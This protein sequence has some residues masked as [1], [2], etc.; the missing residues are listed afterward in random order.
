MARNEDEDTPYFKTERLIGAGPYRIGTKVFLGEDLYSMYFASTLRP[1]LV[2]Y[3]IKVAPT[4]KKEE[5][6]DLI[7]RAKT[8][9]VFGL[10]DDA[11]DKNEAS[12]SEQPGSE[13]EKPT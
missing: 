1:E 2:Y 7:S 8:E 9:E 13:D 4:L 5:E 11:G 6:E 12:T 10:G 3:H